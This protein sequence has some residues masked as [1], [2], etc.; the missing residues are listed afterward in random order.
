LTAIPPIESRL[1]T[2]KALA[3]LDSKVP[4][5]PINVTG[6]AWGGS[7]NAPNQP[8]AVSTVGIY[9]SANLVVDT[10][11]QGTVRLWSLSPGR[12]LTGWGGTTENFVRIGHSLLVWL[13]AWLGGQLSRSLHGRP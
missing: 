10:N 5:R 11:A 7:P 3:Y 9:Q 12:L 6:M 8:V 1:P 2:T 4:G 13:I